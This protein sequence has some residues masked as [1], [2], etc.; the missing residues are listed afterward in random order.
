VPSRFVRLPEG[1]TGFEATGK[2]VPSVNW[3]N[4]PGWKV[5]ECEVGTLVLID[6]AVIHRVR[7][8]ATLSAG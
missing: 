7:L 1:G 6:G 3:A 5:E 8:I 4:E 2:P